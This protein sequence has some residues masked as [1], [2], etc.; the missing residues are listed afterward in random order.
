MNQNDCIIGFPVRRTLF[1]RT[2][3]PSLAPVS[4]NSRSGGFLFA[5]VIGPLFCVAG[6]VVAAPSGYKSLAFS[7]AIL[8]FVLAMFIV[9]ELRQ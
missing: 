1:K 7:I 5:P 4:V 8:L 6:V 2:P 3:T 9:T